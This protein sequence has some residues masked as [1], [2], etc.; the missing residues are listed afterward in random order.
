MPKT[1]NVTFFI[2]K[3]DKKYQISHKIVRGDSATLQYL[4]RKYLKNKFFI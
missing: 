2:Q 1:D 3:D 4:I